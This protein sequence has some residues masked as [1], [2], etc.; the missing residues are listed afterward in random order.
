VASTFAAVF[1]NHA[2]NITK[3]KRRVDA[4]VAAAR[5]RRARH[6]AGIAVYCEPFLVLPSFPPRPGFFMSNTDS[7]CAN[8]LARETSPYL[9]Q[10][11]HNPVDWYPWGEE[12]FA[13]AQ[14]EDK[15]VL[16]SVGYATCHWCH[17]MARESFEDEAIARVL[18]EHFIAIKVD[19][20]ERP[21]VDHVYMSALQALTGQGGWPL[22]LFLTPR[23]LAFYG[24]TY[25]PPRASHSRHGRPGFA[26]VLSGVHEAWVERR[27]EVE[28]SAANLLERL[29]RSQHDRRGRRDGHDSPA[30]RAMAADPH[31]AAADRLALDFDAEH[32]GFGEAPKFPQAPLLH[33]LLTLAAAG[34][35]AARAMLTTTLHAMAAGGLYD[36]IGG[37]FARY[38][39]DGRW[40]VPH[41][42]KMLYDNAQLAQVYIGA[43]RLSG[44]ERLRFIA[45]DTL[46][47]M[48]REMR[49]RAAPAAFSCAIDA[50]SEGEEG[51]FYVWTAAQLRAALDME[52]LGAAAPAAA[53]LYGVT[54]TGNWEH[55]VNVLQRGDAAAAA[56][57]AL[58][59]LSSGDFSA[60]E[61]AVRERLRAARE[62]RERP[63]T[64][65]K[66][67]A[68]SNGMALRA[69]ALAGRLLR[70]ADY[71]AAARAAA[72]FLLDAMRPRQEPRRGARLRHAWPDARL[73]HAWRNG[74]LREESF[75]VDYAQV[76]LG[77]VELHA[78][79]GEIGWLLAARD[80]CEAMLALFYDP[81]EG[82]SDGLPDE[83][84]VPSRA[85]SDGATASGTAAACELALRLAGVFDRGDWADAALRTFERHRALLNLPGA[86]PALAHAHLLAQHGADLALVTPAEN[87]IDI[88]GDFAP[89]ATMVFAA[90]G[91]IPLTRE[92]NAG[93]AYL[94]R[95]GACQ[96]PARSID[97]LRA[98]LAALA[99]LRG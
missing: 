56:A 50:D 63:I 36:Q 11:A 91:E 51:K 85:I 81:G 31:R 41:F 27:A 2:R 90:P 78:A 39:T 79:T 19:R 6:P 28:R 80:L 62:Q 87:L 20:E 97:A 4:R 13:K 58:L 15:P 69:F 57:R 60:W 89:L 49:P 86:A 17:V 46:A 75:L 23:R 32:G 48:L 34:D 88:R 84:P 42:E 74:V 67:L 55:G 52:E 70:R 30:A 14:R 40:H 29:Q 59:G 35:G 95:H 33:Y 83:L 44:D 21:D 98:R 92:R 18:N 82:F 71:I 76:G 38:S 65:D 8:R 47:W 37:G 66:V 5:G 96:L 16:L 64:D 94:C 1:L 68:D 43:W 22:N 61:R 73:R 25:F 93:Q 54:E 3:V 26:D 24:G 53:R 9:S 99:P 7:R 12:A 72:R 10:H 45:E 77:L